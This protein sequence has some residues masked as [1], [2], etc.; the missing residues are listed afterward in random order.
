[1]YLNK[2]T[3]HL[4]IKKVVC[5]GLMEIGIDIM[6]DLVDRAGSV[7]LETKVAVLESQFYELKKQREEDRKEFYEST[8]AALIS[9]KEM[10]SKID[11]LNGFINDVEV[12][13]SVQILSVEKTILAAFAKKENVL[14]TSILKWMFGVI[15]A[16]VIAALLFFLGAK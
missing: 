5:A 9:R 4:E 1:V 6:L 8:S 10:H 14:L 7:P 12:K 15:S 3:N 11:R 2:K 13:L 16:L